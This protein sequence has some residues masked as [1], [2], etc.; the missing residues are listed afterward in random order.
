MKIWYG[1]EPQIGK[2]DRAKMQNQQQPATIV[3]THIWKFHVWNV[4]STKQNQMTKSMAKQHLYTCWEKIC[5][6]DSFVRWVCVCVN[7]RSI[8]L[9]FSAHLFAACSEAYGVYLPR[10]RHTH[11]FR[12]EK[13]GFGFHRQA[14]SVE[15]CSTKMK[16]PKWCH[17]LCCF[18]FWNKFIRDLCSI[19]LC[20]CVCAFANESKALKCHFLGDIFMANCILAPFSVLLD[21]KAQITANKNHHL[22]LILVHFFQ[23]VVC[24][25]CMSIVLAA[26]EVVQD[27]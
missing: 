18:P 11:V 10:N 14:E 6:T 22:D 16:T 2:R 15:P 19:S 13:F 12:I 5:S 20:V 4:W 21:T 1:T 26:S 25:F 8:L 27:L 9:S 7:V 17:F 24:S 23:C 3:S